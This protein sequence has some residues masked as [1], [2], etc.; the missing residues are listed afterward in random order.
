MRLRPIS[1]QLNS[2]LV[3]V[4]GTRLTGDA[5]HNTLGHYAEPA[6]RSEAMPSS[7]LWQTTTYSATGWTR[8]G[9]VNKIYYLNDELDAGRSVGGKVK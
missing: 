7:F 1:S 4:N 5:L 9:L 3:T 2:T 6:R 8:I